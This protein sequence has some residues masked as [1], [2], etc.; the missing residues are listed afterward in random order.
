MGATT[1]TTGKLTTLIHEADKRIV[2]RGVAVT[3]TTI[4]VPDH[5]RGGLFGYVTYD[6]DENKRTFHTEQELVEILERIG[7]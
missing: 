7:K 3:L 5:T 1:L 6:W 4:N 2:G